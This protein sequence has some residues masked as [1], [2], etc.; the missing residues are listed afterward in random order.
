MERRMVPVGSATQAEME[1]ASTTRKPAKACHP[2]MSAGRRRSRGHRLRASPGYWCWVEIR[3]AEQRNRAGPRDEITPPAVPRAATA[4]NDRGWT[5]RLPSPL[6]HEPDESTGHTECICREA[7][8]EHCSLS[9][10]CMEIVG[11]WD[12]RAHARRDVTGEATGRC[13]WG[14]GVRVCMRYFAVPVQHAC[15]GAAHARKVAQRRD[16]DG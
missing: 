14:T 12:G 15:A 6:L 16:K 4:S 10:C 11:P 7:G 9:Y 5:S 8:Q 1:M 2:G 13:R 3:S